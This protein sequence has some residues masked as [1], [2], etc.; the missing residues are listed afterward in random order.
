[1]KLWKLSVHESGVE[2]QQKSIARVQPIDSLKIAG[3]VTSIAVSICKMERSRN[4]HYV[5]LVC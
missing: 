3:E 4:S 5:K 2:E 1:M